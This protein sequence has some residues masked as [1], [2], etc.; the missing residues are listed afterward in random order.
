MFTCSLCGK[1]IAP[2]QTRSHWLNYTGSDQRFVRRA[3]IGWIL[4]IWQVSQYI[5]YQKVSN[6]LSGTR[7]CFYRIFSM[8]DRDDKML[9]IMT[10]AKISTHFSH[11][12]LRSYCRK[13]ILNLLKK[14]EPIKGWKMRFK[15]WLLKKISQSTGMKH[16]KQGGHGCS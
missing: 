11:K 16:I 15:D 2:W 1:A 6:N 13:R 7:Q 4:Q 5:V 3:G 9:K 14:R 12:K 10:K 8:A